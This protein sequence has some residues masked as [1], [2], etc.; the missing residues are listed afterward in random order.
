MTES[1]TP[2]SYVLV[3]SEYYDAQRHPTCAAFRAASAQLL[4]RT[5]PSGFQTQ[6][7]DVGAGDS[8]LAA[9]LHEQGSGMDG[10][11]IADAAAAM[12]EYS[13]RWA[14]HGARL[15]VARADQLPVKD[16]SVSFLLASLADPYDD[17]ALWEEIA[18]V[19]EPGGQALVT[20]PS[21]E[22]A[23]RFRAGTKSSHEA[24][25]ELVDGTLVSVPST[26]RPEAAERRLI[27]G[28]GLRVD[29]VDRVPVGDLAS[30][31]PKLALLHDDEPV[32]T[33]YLASRPS[34]G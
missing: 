5:L 34:F 16:G 8:L 9:A 32:V 27:E 6:W 13:K 3:A 15:A 20:A 29:E 4:S 21:W 17:A 24:I 14:A 11:L 18:R 28:A 12:L 22:W 26:I 30:R 1:D 25:F 7:V 10:L 19:L 2:A 33:G 23:S 31:P